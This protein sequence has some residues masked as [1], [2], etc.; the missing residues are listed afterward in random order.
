MKSFRNPKYLER[1]EDVFFELE[2]PLNTTAPAN[3]ASQ[4]KTGYR[5]VVDNTG[6]VTPFD[7]YNARISMTFK[8][9]TMANANLVANDENNIVNGSHSFIN[10]FDVKLNGRKVYDCNDAN[11]AVN[12]KNLLEYSPDYAQSTATNEFFYLDT[13]REPRFQEAAV[14][15]G[16][17]ARKT[18]L[19]TSVNVPTEI[20]LNRYSFFEALRDEL[21]PATRLELNLE[22]ESDGNLIWRTGGAACRVMIMRMQLVV[23]RITFNSEGQSLYINQ[24]MKPHKWI[25][26]RENIERSNSTTRRAGVFQIT[27]GIERPRHVFVF[28]INDANVDAQTANPFLYNTFS[29][30]TDP[31]TLSNAHLVVGNGNEYPDVHYTPEVNINRV[32]RDI[33]KYVH[34]NNEYGQGTLLNTSNFKSL[35][36]FLY[37]DLTKQKMDIRDGTTKLAFHYELSGT[38][39]AAYSIYA[40]TLY[41]QDAELVQKDGKLLFR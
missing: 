41:E 13:S 21:L 37:F 22:I 23:P 19:G 36:G 33:M 4:K 14:S 11:H 27:S 17:K 7:W 16:A 8:V 15:V 28:I 12:I 5:F 32:Y 3:N 29:V 6:E 30:S 18:L 1:Y 24:F 38:T 9:Q 31:R 20:S 10:N 40:L 34:A 26:L 25:Y 39:A 35:F 2:T